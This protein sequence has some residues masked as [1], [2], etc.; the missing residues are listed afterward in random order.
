VVLW[1][2]SR[3]KLRQ[4]VTAKGVHRLDGD[5]DRHRGG[6]LVGADV[7]VRLDRA[8]DL[9]RVADADCVGLDA[10]PE[11]LGGRLGRVADLLTKYNDDLVPLVQAETGSTN[12]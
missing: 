1:T 2:G 9:V 6:K 8:L 3:S 4:D 11:D 12:W 5:L 10:Q 7:D